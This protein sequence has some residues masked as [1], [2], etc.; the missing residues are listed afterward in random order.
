MVIHSDI[1]L[2][3]DSH[4]GEGGARAPHVL[5]CALRALCSG[6]PSMRIARYNFCRHV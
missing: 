2:L 4:A 3:R 5:M 1:N 6:L